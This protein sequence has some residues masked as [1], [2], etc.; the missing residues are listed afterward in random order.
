M[1]ETADDAEAK[2]MALIN[3]L[4]RLSKSIYNYINFI[5]F[6]FKRFVRRTPMEESQNIKK[7]PKP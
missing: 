6:G 7:V 3:I 4:R 2:D 1:R 5:D